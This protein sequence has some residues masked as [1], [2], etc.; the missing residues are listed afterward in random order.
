MR[1]TVADPVAFEAARPRLLAVAYRITG[2]LA[3]AEDVVQEAWLRWAAEPRD[4][5]CDPVAFLVTVTARLA[6]DRRRRIAARRESYTGEWLPQPVSTTSDPAR[7]VEG[8]DAIGYGLL[9]VL[10]TLSPLERAVYVLR[11]AFGY[12][13][14]EIGRMLERSDAAVRQV[15][16]RARAHVEARIE[17]FDPDRS[18]AAVA[19]ERFLAAASGGDLAP[20]LELLAPDVE[21]VADG[22]GKVRAPLLPVVGREAVGRFLHAVRNRAAPDAVTSIESLNGQP[23]IVVR[24]GTAVA[25]ALLFHV[26]RDAVRRMFLVGNPDKLLG[27]EGDVTSG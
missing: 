20:L 7:R 17:R 6:L 24:L 16:H 10:E 22:G 12:S 21:L 8:L 26:D 5:V 9:V 11:E 3:D 1:P 2:Q 19:A 4:E 13:H 25:A 15:A 27:V 14:S 23:A 18:L